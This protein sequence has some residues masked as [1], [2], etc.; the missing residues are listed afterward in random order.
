MEYLVWYHC[1]MSKL[2][3]I[4]LYDPGITQPQQLT[5][6][7]DLSLIFLSKLT[8][9]F[10]VQS[11]MKIFLLALKFPYFLQ[12]FWTQISPH[13]HEQKFHG[14][15]HLILPNQC[16]ISSNFLWLKVSIC[17]HQ[18]FLLISSGFKVQSSFVLKVFCT[19]S[20]DKIW[21]YI[22]SADFQANLSWKYHQIVSI[23]DRT[24]KNAI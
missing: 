13:H 14:F 2:K 16:D 3:P 22:L 1:D 12:S 18:F 7:L 24:K 4:S 5:W 15:V 21:W 19:I 11:E 17:F 10:C 9:F 8:R 6:F 23:K 20:I